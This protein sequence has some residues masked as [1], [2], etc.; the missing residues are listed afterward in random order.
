MC[1]A[2]NKE[3]AKKQNVTVDVSFGACREHAFSKTKSTEESFLVYFP[4]PNNSCLA[5]GRDVNINFKK[6]I[7]ALPESEQNDKGR[8]SIMLW[9]WTDNVIEEEGSPALGG[10]DRKGAKAVID[11][12]ALERKRAK[13]LRRREKR[14]VQRT[15][16]LEETKEASTE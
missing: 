3:R 6:G 8:I 10:D 1:S 15:Q 4:Q 16:K 11:T 14:Q 7:N 9:G 13:N 5:F 12:K 2:F